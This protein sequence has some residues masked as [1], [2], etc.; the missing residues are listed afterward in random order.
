MF[1]L[2]LF[3]GEQPFKLD[4]PIR[5]I[6]LFA[7]YG[8]QAL[9][10]KYLGVPFEHHRICEWAVKSIQAYKDLHFT[11]DNTDYS[12]GF[13]EREI[14]EKLFA[15]SI[16]ADYNKPMTLKEVIRLKEGKARQ[17]YNN[18]QATHNL[19]SVCNATAE[20]LGISDT[21]KYIYIM[22]YSFPCQDLSPAG[23]G[24]GM[25]KDS[26]TRSGLLWEVERILKECKQLPQ[27]LIM[28][29]VPQVVGKKNMPY[30]ADW[31]K[32][33]DDLGYKSK[34]QILN[35]T[36]Y[37]VPQNRERCFM[38]SVLG[39]YFY[40]FPQAI[41]CDLKLKDV[42]ETNVPESYYLKKGTIIK[43]AEHKARH[44]AQGHGFGWKPIDPDGGGAAIS[45]TITNSQENYPVRVKQLL[46]TGGF[47]SKRYDFS[48]WKPLLDMDFM[49]SHRCCGEM[50]KK[51]LNHLGKKAIVATMTEESMLRRTAW[52]QTGCNAF[53]AGVSKPMSFWTEQDVLQYIKRY[54]LPIASVYGDIVYET[55]D[56]L[57]YD[58][59]LCDCGGKLCT[60]GCH[61]TGCVYCAFGAQN[62]MRFV[63]LKRTHPRHYDYCMGGG[64]YDTDGLW[65][66]TKEGLGMAHCIDEIN[67]VYGA[68]F[69]RY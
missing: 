63:D 5:L 47:F 32:F 30:F 33:L 22:T 51:P 29:N 10:L 61:R 14:Y 64:A 4:K 57:R 56:G 60:T 48:K 38:V 9:A 36:G 11:N 40:N 8:S 26:G 12:A 3:D 7:G 35:A 16:S 20:M 23:K 66:P 43:L 67:K 31:L 17:V 21:D 24:K 27:V 62:T 59:C 53:K 52:L 19:V 34:W 58:S 25:A 65:K 1:Q 41:G 6:E 15:Y 28:E 45:S 46:G 37:G 68:N 55:K 2:S 39:D 54:D 13:T 50:K 18:I 49:I 44:E 42:L 69:I